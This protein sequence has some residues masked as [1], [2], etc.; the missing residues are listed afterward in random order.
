MNAQNQVILCV[1]DDEANR[2]LLKNILVPRGYVVVS[3]AGGAEALQMLRSQSIDLVLLDVLMP[4]MDG[5]EVCRQIKEDQSLRN[6]P[7][8]MITALTATAD[9]IR[10]IEAG[11]EEFLSK[12]FD[13]AEALARIKLLLKVKELN[14][15][16]DRAEEALLQSHTELERLVQERTAALA[17]AIVMLQADIAK[18][19]KA[20]NR[21][22]RQL[23]HLTALSTIDRVIASNFD[24]GLSLSEI[25]IHVTTE[26]GVD[27]ADILVLNSISQM[28]EF[29]AGR[30]FRTKAAETMQ[31]R[32]GECHAGRA[33]L[34][35]QIV[36]ISNLNE[37]TDN[38]LLP[39]CLA[40]E[41]FVYYFGVPL[42]AKGQVKGVLEVFQ[43]A[44]LEP[45]AEWLNFLKSLAG[46]TA[47]A[48]DNASMFDSLQRSNSEL[49]IAYEATMEGWSHAL[50]LRDR[51][52][53]GHSQRVS[54]TTVR[55]ARS[56]G[57]S[58]ED[59]ILLRHGALLHDI[60][61]MGIPDTILLK[62]GPLTEEEW[63][64]MRQHP[65]LSYELLAPISYLRAAID[66]PYCHH[67]KWDG[68]GYPRGL[69]AEQIPLAARIFAVV[70]VWDAL[71]SDR[72]YRA[73]WPKDK[74]RKHILSLAGTHF[75]P[76][77][78]ARFATEMAN[79]AR[80]P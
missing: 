16:R 20:E 80:D 46:Q 55:L 66:I 15:D 70:D 57:L 49:R 77:V 10:G 1:D 13:Q 23:E 32:L 74:V 51:E 76:A 78:V 37:Q 68:S 61:K 2:K 79:H 59:L 43:R 42:I 21:I 62:P 72:P 29:G 28:L 60:G 9:R 4:L 8:I 73:A 47:I 3:A 33:A 53:E 64:V 14:D 40:G 19:E 7:V 27:A 67:E 31:V 5:F 12:P 26:L 63:I 39:K 50:D 35:R 22:Q 38:S 24:L 58:E 18:R 52:T 34:D 69:K 45:D 48:I 17:Q 75:D 65:K 36:E 25:L 30:G 6:I 54:D 44:G 56:F 11:A 71:S 41:D